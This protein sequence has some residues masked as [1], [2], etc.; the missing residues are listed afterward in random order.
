MIFLMEFDLVKISVKTLFLLMLL[1]FLG[2]CSKNN[3][4]TTSNEVYT[5]NNVQEISL[6]QKDAGFEIKLPT[7]LPEDYKFNNVVYAQEK[8]T[9]TVKYIW[10]NSDFNGEMLTVTQQL[11][12]PEGGY[13]SDAKVEDV[14]LGNVWAKFVQGGV[15]NGKWDNNAPVYSLRW[16]AHDYYFT[17]LFT[18]SGTNSKGF[19][20][21]EQLTKLAE[22]LLW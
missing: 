22:Q 8:Q 7:K 18:S 6:A 14:L 13:A 9:L 15:S 21:K 4:A 19:I 2:S 12:K 10:A 11:V 5:V 16:Q 20:S 1:L 3:A 17:L